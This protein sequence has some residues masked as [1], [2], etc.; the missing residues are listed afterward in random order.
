MS[1][2]LLDVLRRRLGE[3]SRREAAVAETIL[4][5]PGA[6]LQTSVGTL[7]A[8]AGV[9]QPTVIRLCRS[10]GCDGF[11]DFKLRLAQSLVPGTPFVSA[12]VAPSDSAPEYVAKIFG[13]AAAALEATRQSLEIGAI[14]EAVAL[15]AS[16]RRIAFFG[17]GGS[18]ATAIDAQHKFCRFSAPVSAFSDPLMLRMTLTGMGAG[19]VLVAIS[20]T[21]R[22]RAVIEAAELAAAMRVAVV[23]VTAPRSPLAEAA[24]VA[25]A[26]EPAEDAELFTPMASRIAHLAVI[27]ALAIGVALAQG[28]GI[29]ERLARLKESL[30]HTRLPAPAR[31]SRRRGR[32]VLPKAED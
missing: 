11:S 21:G 2:N 4:A 8:R 25:V 3:L 30:S 18:A 23:A 13:A 22:T 6:V 32:A 28:P 16:A 27:D 24:A 20:N 9:S 29:M 5:E 7:A 12:H 15:L 10:V 14:E 31:L 26:V 1:G 17:L 19:D